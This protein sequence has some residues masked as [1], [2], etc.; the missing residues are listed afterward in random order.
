MNKASIL[1]LSFGLVS[2]PA[3]SVANDFSTETRVQYVIECMEANPK[4]IIYE[5]VHKC[6][7]VVD[8]IAE[9]FTQVQFEQAN[10]GFQMKNMPADRGGVFRDDADVEDGISNF[11]QV[12]ALAYESCRIR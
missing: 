12:Q 5:A 3:I 6:S 8:K 2:L 1:L 10:T 7:C 4:M 9:Q 11:T